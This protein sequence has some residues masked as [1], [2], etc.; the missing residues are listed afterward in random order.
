[1]WRDRVL[2]GALVPAAV[3]EGIV[4]AELPWRVLPVAVTVGLVPTL[5][6][7]RTRPLL[8]VAI[9]FGTCAVALLVTRGQ[10]N[11]SFRLSASGTQTG[12]LTVTSNASNSPTTVALPGTGTGTGSV[13]LATGRHTSES[14]HTDVYQSSNVTDGNQSSYCGSAN[15]AF[16]QWKQVDLGSAQSASRVVLQL[17]A[18]WG[19]RDETLSL[20]ASTHGTNLTTVTASATYTFPQRAAT[21]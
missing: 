14:S 21:R 19:A 13:H 1:V 12:S 10:F 17:P 7:R 11:V 9:G 8:M 4:R 18:S 15:N 20:L 3:L 2:A 6:W 16:S 5:P